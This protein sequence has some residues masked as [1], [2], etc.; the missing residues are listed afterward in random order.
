MRHQVLIANEIIESSG[1]IEMKK[2]IFLPYLPCF[3][4]TVSRL[5]S[6]SYFLYWTLKPEVHESIKCSYSIDFEKPYWIFCFRDA[7]AALVFK[8]TWGGL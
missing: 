3:S 6:E 2:D 8:L 1:I 5:E 7:S 4:V